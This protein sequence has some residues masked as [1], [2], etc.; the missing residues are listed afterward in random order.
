MYDFFYSF[1][2]TDYTEGCRLNYSFQSIRQFVFNEWKMPFNDLV[3]QTNQEGLKSG[4][5]RRAPFL[6]EMVDSLPPG[7]F[8]SCCTFWN[9]TAWLTCSLELLI[10]DKSGFLKYKCR[11]G[12]RNLGF[13]SP[14]TAFPPVGPTY[15]LQSDKS[16]F[17][18][19]FRLKNT[20][21]LCSLCLVEL[22]TCLLLVR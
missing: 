12:W 19:H 2:R 7:S 15:Q 18:F 5:Q 11:S 9:Y 22:L 14:C 16:L 21:L 13:L 4:S 1:K 10:S 3:I 6:L 8:P 17:S 20:R